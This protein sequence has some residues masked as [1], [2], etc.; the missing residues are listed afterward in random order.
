MTK[1][2]LID[3]HQPEETRVV[4]LNGNKIEEF[5][6]ENNNFKQL[7]GNVYLARVTRVEPS[8]QAAFVEYGGNRQGFLAFSEIHPDY[9]RIPIED[10]EALE[11]DN[12]QESE[13]DASD[14]DAANATDKDNDTPETLGGDDEEQRSRSS[15]T[16]LLRRYKIQ[17]VI[18]RKQILLIQ[19]VKEERGNKGA[20]LTTY[21][22]LA[23]RY[24]VL[25]PN[26]NRG[27]GVSRKIT[28]VAD[29]K[30]L[31]SV[32]NDLEV[33]DGMAVIVRTAGSKRTKTE[34][35]RDYAYLS[36]LWNDIRATTLQSEAPAIIHE[37]GSLVKRAIRDIYT[38]DVESVLVE[39]DEAYKTAKNQMKMLIP[40]HAKRV[41]K[42]DEPTH[43]FQTQN[44]EPQLDTIHQGEVTLKSGGY[45]VLNQTE[46]LVAIDVNSG[47]ATRER[48]I[49]ETALKT[50]LEAAEEVGRQLRL[51]DL[52]GLIVIDFIDME[53]NRNQHAVERKLKDSLRNDRARIQIGSISHFGLLEMSRQ[54]LRASLV[55][56]VSQACPHCAGTGRIRSI[57]SSALHILRVIEEEAARHQAKEMTVF[58]HPEVALYVLNQ[59]RASL[60]ALESQLGLSVF[61][62][63]D[64]SLSPQDYRIGRKDDQPE[65][66][67]ASKQN[68]RPRPQQAEPAE[69]KAREV[70]QPSDND[71]TEDDEQP[72]RRRRGRRGGRRRKNRNGEEGNPQEI[73]ASETGD[74]GNTPDAASAPSTG[75]TE[76]GTAATGDAPAS[77]DNAEKP[78]KKTRSRGRRRPARGADDTATV[79][80]TDAA[81]DSKASDTDTASETAAPAKTSPP[82]GDAV[83]PETPEKTAPKAKKAARASS[84]KRA[85][86]KVSTN[87]DTA[88]TAEASPI[89]KEKA[90]AKTS[91]AAKKPARKKAAKAGVPKGEA[92]PASETPAAARAPISSAEVDV[93]NVSEAAPEK[94]KRGWWSRS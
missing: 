75:T 28:N 48:N 42:H 49:E 67:P 73:S 20:A 61:L 17:E 27:G 34:I 76:N 60:A 29:R 3:A 41:I 1:K 90:P 25:M 11:K 74:T 52:S 39:G 78:A 7:K 9:Y 94:K 38:N 22:S 89:V 32:V 23:G 2:M 10:R 53:E 93:V 18:V 79:T 54:R 16:A 12:Q 62:E 33:P 37:E 92:S 43:L 44:V 46:A 84:G 51:R 59:K 35:K 21:L 55:E 77:D 50:N 71:N 36:K 68:R 85:A 14:D 57:N 66:R 19:V 65:A 82:A 8:L 40:S 26:S 56:S 31:K 86:K 30:R 87:S 70:E 15:S 88:D 45:L 47:K 83:Q 63:A 24:C 81:S 13:E 4:L 5:D 64:A 72:K 58:I 6:Y 80:G 69:S 91:T